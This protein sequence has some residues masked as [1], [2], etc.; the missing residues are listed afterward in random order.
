MKRSRIKKKSKSSLRI[1]KDRLWR[2]LKELVH[3]RDGNVCI[4]C[5][6]KNLKGHNRHAGHFIPSAA[7][8]GFLRYDL[9]NVWSQ[10]ARCNMFLG[11][12]GAEYT[13]A[14]E[15]MYG[16]KFVDKIIADKQ[17]TIKLD[18]HYVDGLNEYYKTLL[19]KKPK[20]LLDL[21]KKYKGYDP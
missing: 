13:R 8:G 11:G 5:G 20:E 9:R 16:V 12:A 17:H 4:T 14:L 10:C 18:V 6:A 1:A 21:T 3:L 7:C 15:K 19:D 2:T